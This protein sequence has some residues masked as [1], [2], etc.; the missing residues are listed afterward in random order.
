MAAGIGLACSISEIVVI[1]YKPAIKHRRKVLIDDETS[2]L[3]FSA[4]VADSTPCFT[5][6]KPDQ[7]RNHLRPAAAEMNEGASG[8]TEDEFQSSHSSRAHWWF[9]LGFVY[10]VFRKTIPGR[11]RAANARERAHPPPAN[12]AKPLP[13]DLNPCLRRPGASH[14]PCACATFYQAAPPAQRCFFT[15]SGPWP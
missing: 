9:A 4:A 3:V 14:L 2:I 6:P 13:V 11:K 1:P 8:K 10:S 7:M 12:Q 5:A 15:T